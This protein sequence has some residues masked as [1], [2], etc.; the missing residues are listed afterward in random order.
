MQ[1]RYTLGLRELMTSIL[2]KASFQY[3]DLPERPASQARPDN[4]NLRNE[5]CSI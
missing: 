2:V 3:S 4:H 1:A 5:I